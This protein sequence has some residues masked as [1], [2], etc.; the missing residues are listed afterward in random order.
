MTNFS[1]MVNCRIL[2]G[3]IFLLLVSGCNTQESKDSGALFHWF[4]YEGN[5]AF[6]E[7]HSLEEGEYGNFTVRDD[8]TGD[9]LP[10]HWNFIHTPLTRWYSIEEGNVKIDFQP[11]SFRERKN[12]AFIGRRQQHLKF[13][14]TSALSLLPE[15][16]GDHAGLVCFRTETNN[17]FL[18]VGTDNGEQ[19][20]FV[21]KTIVREGKPARKRLA[22][23]KT[24]LSAGQTIYL[25][26]RGGED[27]IDFLISEDNEEWESLA[28][29]QDATYLSAATKGGVVNTYIGMY[30][31]SK[32]E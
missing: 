14:V 6:Y 26:I 28:E 4:E 10:Y 22:M 18:G 23:K 17:Y 8:F 5:D 20:A 27:I 9:S 25:K 19:I 30:A 7:D 1:N 31:S 12:P 13:S 29:G 3:F 2:I 11:V 32:Q 24:G 16:S 21:E 15:G